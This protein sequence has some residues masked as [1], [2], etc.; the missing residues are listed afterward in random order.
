ME[1]RLTGIEQ[2]LDE[3]LEDDYLDRYDRLQLAQFYVYLNLLASI[4]GSLNSC[5]EAL[6]A[7]DWQQLGETRF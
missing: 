2:R 5:R 7:L 3:F 6:V 4:L 1:S